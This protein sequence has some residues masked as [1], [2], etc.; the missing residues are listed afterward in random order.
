MIHSGKEDLR[1]RRANINQKTFYL[2]YD[3]LDD[4]LRKVQNELAQ[5]FIERTKG[6][7]RPRDLDKITREFFLSHEELGK[8]GQRKLPLHKPQNHQ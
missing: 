6:L 2:H 1:T 4:L 3:S 8:L 5:A 7:K